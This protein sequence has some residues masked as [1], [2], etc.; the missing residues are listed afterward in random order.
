VHPRLDAVLLLIFAVFNWHDL[1]GCIPPFG[2]E[3]IEDGN[4]YLNRSEKHQSWLA[5][6]YF[7][8]YSDEL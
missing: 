6:I 5:P 8:K 7:L 3:T 1:N 2:E 4:H